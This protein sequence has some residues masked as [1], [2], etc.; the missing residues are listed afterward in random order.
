MNER[1]SAEIFGFFMI[2]FTELRDGLFLC[3]DNTMS[4]VQGH[5]FGTPVGYYTVPRSTLYA[6]LGISLG[7]LFFGELVL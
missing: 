4:L 2:L 5:G 7:V 3:Q 1:V 6:L